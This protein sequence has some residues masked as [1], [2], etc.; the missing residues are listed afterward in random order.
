RE[1]ARCDWE[2]E[3]VEEAALLP[4]AKTL[5][6]SKLD[7]PVQ[8]RFFRRSNFL[9]LRANSTD[10]EGSAPPSAASAQA[11]TKCHGSPSRPCDRHW[12]RDGGFAGAR[13]IVPKL[14]RSA[15]RGALFGAD[16]T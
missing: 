2:M 7:R 9:A 12:H 4:A 15:R 11:S 14:A 6:S 3:E 16:G 13:S 10:R 5:R 8:Y 1:P